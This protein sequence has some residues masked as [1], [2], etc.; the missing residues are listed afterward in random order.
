M[1]FDIA[2]HDVVGTLGV[3]MIVGCYFLIQIGKMASADLSYSLVNGVGSALIIASLMVEWNWSGF[4]IE[5]FWLL[6]SI[7]GVALWWRRRR[8]TPD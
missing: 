3:L 6:I 2:W 7:M 1:P 4:L 8:R 5:F